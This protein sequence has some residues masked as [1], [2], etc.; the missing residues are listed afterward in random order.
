M[1]D[2]ETFCRI[3]QLAEKDGL[4]TTQIA[5]ELGLNWRTVASWREQERFQE[6]ETAARQSILD[7]YKDHIQRLLE[8]YDYTIAQV[9]LKIREQ[10]YPG[11]E[12]IVRGVFRPPGGSARTCAGMPSS[13]RSSATTFRRPLFSLSHAASC[14]RTC[15]QKSGEVMRAAGVTSFWRGG[16]DGTSAFSSTRGGACAMVF[17]DAA[18]SSST[19]TGGGGTA[20]SLHSFFPAAGFAAG[21]LGGGPGGEELRPMSAVRPTAANSTPPP[22]TMRR[23][24]FRGS[25]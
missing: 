12:T 8:K 14:S 17:G 11:G 4:N 20:A 6:R 18:G 7:P 9:L 19:L 25:S 23:L 21:A 13:G 22:G 15:F 16:E 1:I 2:Y 24:S 10:G 3:K 5:R